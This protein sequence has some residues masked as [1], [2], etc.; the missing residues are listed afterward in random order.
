MPTRRR[1]NAGTR[2][3][4]D[5]ETERRG[6][7]EASEPGSP[8]V[9]PRLPASPRLRVPASL[10][11]LLSS[12]LLLLAACGSP[13]EP[14][15]PLLNVP[16]RTT[17]LEAA[18]RAAEIVLRWTIPAQTTE[19][20][21]AKDLDR[22][23]VLGLELEGESVDSKMFEAGARTLAVLEQP[24]AG[25][26]VERRLPLPA[27]PGK[28]LAL[29]VKN[30]SLRGRAEG[31]SNLVVLQIAAVLPAPASLKAAT[32]PS[33]VRLEWPRVP[34]ARGYRVYRSS[35]EQPQFR[36]VATVVAPPFDDPDFQWNK[37]YAYL[38]RA[39]ANVSPGLAESAD[40][41]TVAVV[42]TDVFPPST[43]EG[44]RAVVTDTSVELSWSLSPEPDTAGY[45]IYRRTA[46]GPPARLNGSPLVV[47]VFSDKNIRRGQQYF[48]AVSALDDKNNESVP[49][50]PF[51][52]N[53]P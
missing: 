1:G 42:P 50:A 46:S 36:F 31:L 25:E 32:L 14:L 45:Y 38:V 24:R 2:E 16:A 43:P 15:P 3:P 5:A 28:R 12:L 10:L 40:S 33:T 44:L 11:S 49:S 17:D 6:D 26:P 47:P 51:Q 29:A 41:P 30:Y 7:T 52:V 8:G 37:P 34:G 48:Y 27:A 53:I 22:V 20:L 39:C 4:Q 18:Q 35:T 13:G 21:P 19:G 9:S 23:V